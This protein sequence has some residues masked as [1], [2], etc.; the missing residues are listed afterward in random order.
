MGWRSVTLSLGARV[1]GDLSERHRCQRL[2]DFGE[3]FIRVVAQPN[4]GGDWD[5]VRDPVPDPLANG[6]DQLRRP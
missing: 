1:N 5:G 3:M 2:K 4:L 6:S